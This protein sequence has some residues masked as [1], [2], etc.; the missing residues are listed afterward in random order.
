[1][2][3]HLHSMPIRLKNGH[4]THWLRKPTPSHLYPTTACGVRVKEFVN[5]VPGHATC[6]RC[7]HTR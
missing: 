1:M 2:T 6:Q 4:A 5:H 3:R 7:T